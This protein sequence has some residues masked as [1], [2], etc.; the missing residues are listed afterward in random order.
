MAPGP[1]SIHRPVS[2]G[3]A[4]LDRSAS[5]NA[6]EQLA[7][8][9]TR[10]PPTPP[11]WLVTFS[12]RTRAVARHMTPDPVVVEALEGARGHEVEALLA[13]TPH[14]ELREHPAAGVERMHQAAP[15]RC[16]KECGS[17][18]A[19]RGI[20]PRPD[21]PRGTSRTRSCPA[22]RRSSPRSGTR[23]PRAR[24][25]ANRRNDQSS[26]GSTSLGREPVRPLPAELLAEHRPQRLQPVVARRSAQRAA[27][28][29]RSSSG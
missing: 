18:P 2:H 28:R 13:L 5:V 15:G 8:L 26:T 4:A 12:N 1:T 29:G 9:R 25:R 16:G 21:P 3:N 23:G 6:R 22:G 24:T 19:G 27:Q 7:G 20:P 17:P 14:R 10:Y 11:S